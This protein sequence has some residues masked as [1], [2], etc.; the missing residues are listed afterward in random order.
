MHNSRRQSTANQVR[1]VLVRPARSVAQ[2]VLAR[3]QLAPC[4]ACQH[5]CGG[6]CVGACTRAAAVLGRSQWLAR[7]VA[8]C[9]HARA[10]AAAAAARARRHASSSKAQR[11]R[12]RPACLPAC[13]PVACPHH[14]HPCPA[15]LRHRAAPRTGVQ[16]AGGGVA[17]RSGPG[18][19]PVPIGASV[20][21]SMTVGTRP[22]NLFKPPFMKVGAVNPI[23]NKFEPVPSFTCVDNVAPID[24]NTAS[25]TWE[26]PFPSGALNY[27][28]TPNGTVTIVL[29][30]SSF[31]SCDNATASATGYP[32]N[33]TLTGDTL[34]ITFESPDAPP[35]ASVLVDLDCPVEVRGVLAQTPVCPQSCVHARACL[36]CGPHHGA[37]VHIAACTQLTRMCARG[38][39]A[40]TRASRHPCLPACLPACCRCCCARAL[41]CGDNPC[42]DPD[43]GGPAQQGTPC[44]RVLGFCD[45]RAHTHTHTHTHMHS[46]HAASMHCGVTHQHSWGLGAC[47]GPA[48]PHAHATTCGSG[49]SM[50]PTRTLL[51]R[52]CAHAAAA[53]AAAGV[54]VPC[55][56]C[57]CAR[58]RTG[59]PHNPC[60]SVD[61]VCDGQNLTCPFPTNGEKCA[62]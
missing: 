29:Q 44:R 35:A 38:C 41:Q 40:L 16:Q 52:F 3:Q 37:A 51:Q 54:G 27:P 26:V 24:S 47:E 8:R 23:P 30:S 62:W 42:C 49:A 46:H 11:S 53:A 6:T 1:A 5:V 4:S 28:C 56:A 39:V 19:L 2:F 57:C 7:A 15:V 25:Y 14:D 22:T 36:V 17:M 33:A 32:A 21:G 18:Q 20:T 55:C 13:L 12:Q 59:D 31:R 9:A 60:D 10:A 50:H 61:Q 45:A 58:H 43:T 48:P 34:V